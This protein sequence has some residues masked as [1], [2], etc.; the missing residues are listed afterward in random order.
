MSI[1][2]IYPTLRRTLRYPRMGITYPF[3]AF[4]EILHKERSLLLQKH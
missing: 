3:T 1:T 2:D 4:A